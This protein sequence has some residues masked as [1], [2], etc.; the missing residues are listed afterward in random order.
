MHRPIKIDERKI[1]INKAQRF[2]ELAVF[3]SSS[4]KN[5]IKN[6]WGVLLNLGCYTKLMSV[7]ER[8]EKAPLPLVCIV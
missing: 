1:K 5:K 7:P 3:P 8:L 4:I 2:G 6:G